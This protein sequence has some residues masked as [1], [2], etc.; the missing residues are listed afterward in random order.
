VSS[1]E[2]N[3]KKATE[4]YYPD[5]D[6]SVKWSDDLPEDGRKTLGDWL[7]K[8]TET[9]IQPV[10][11]A[12]SDATT[13]IDTTQHPYADPSS[14]KTIYSE[15]D[16]GIDI[17]TGVV[18]LGPDGNASKILHKVAPT[19]STEGTYLDPTTQGA[20]TTLGRTSE[21]LTKNRFSPG[22][23]FGTGTDK[24]AN[25]Q[26]TDGFAPAASL[27]RYNKDFEGLA[28]KELTMVAEQLLL[29]A[30]GDKT[31]GF[32]SAGKD[33][34][35]F[36]T[37]A[38]GI[39]GTQ[40]GGKRD[41]FDADTMFRPAYAVNAAKS[42]DRTKTV[43][44]NGQMQAVMGELNSDQNS[45]TS[46]GVLNNHLE[47]FAPALPT[48][49]ILLAAIG[50]IAS[51]IAAIVLALI[52]DVLGAIVSLIAGNG[53]GGGMNPTPIY[54]LDTEN[55]DPSKLP[56][57]AAFG[58]DDFGNTDFFSSLYKF[59]GLPPLE[60]KYEKSFH[61]TLATVTGA[62]EFFIGNSFSRVAIPQITT[63]AAG[64][65]VVIVRNAIRDM[66]QISKA[67]DE[68]SGGGT[69]GAIEGF[70]GLIDAF[71]SSATFK[72]MLTMVQI[73]DRIRTGPGL[74]GNQDNQ[75]DRWL[76]QRLLENSPG[77]TQTSDLG[78]L[79]RIKSDSPRLSYG[80]GVLPQIY[81]RP[82]EAFVRDD[83]PTTT[84]AIDTNTYSDL[85][86]MVAGGILSSDTI[87]GKSVVPLE[88]GLGGGQTFMNKLSYFENGR[89]STELREA[90][91]NE[92]NTYYMPFYFHDLRTNEIIP[93]PA[94]VSAISDAFS[95]KYSE[96]SSFGRM[97]PVM[98]Y[99]GTT[100]KIGFSFYMVATNEDDY[101]A[102]Y[103]GINK[104]VSLVY[105]QWGGATQISNA[106]GETFNRP[107]S[108]VQTA[109]PLIRLRLG[110]L[111]AS[112]RTPET[113]RRL[114]G[115]NLEE[116]RQADP[117][118]QDSSSPVQPTLGDATEQANIAA[119]DAVAK[120]ANELKDPTAHTLIKGT[121]ITNYGGEA[122]IA[123]YAGTNPMGSGG[124]MTLSGEPFLLPHGT[125]VRIKK[126]KYPAVEWNGLNDYNILGRSTNR[127]GSKLGGCPASGFD[128]TIMNYYIEGASKPA[129]EKNGGYLKNNIFYVV[130][131]YRD[132]AG[133]WIVPISNVTTVVSHTV[134]TFSPVPPAPPPPPL[135]DYAFFRDNI[136]VKS[137][138]ESGG[139]G[140]AGTIM[141]LDFDWNEAP[142][143]TS[144]ELGRAPKYVKVSLSFAPIHDEPL[145][146]NPDGSLRAAAYPVGDVITNIMGPRFE[147]PG[148]PPRWLQ[149]ENLIAAATAIT[150][151]NTIA[152]DA[153]SDDPSL[154]PELGQ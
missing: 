17:K 68:M 143:E 4:I 127:G 77:P 141:S 6:G 80:F 30:V 42:A 51:I 11:T 81:I 62:L 26:K 108:Y 49:M 8:I 100:R 27:G 32:G 113:V 86:S 74:L 149:H 91:E 97:D 61:F 24:W 28:M 129:I 69:V 136:L 142:W 13:D 125:R 116:F 148:Q 111:F 47:Q 9:N 123:N 121:Q 98:I 88:G 20:G 25:T 44:I 35:T 23:S 102:L 38:G 130:H 144:S 71:T 93:L 110:E 94:F 85:Q 14:I 45:R 107:Y 154:E 137:M 119:L 7:N 31:S 92:L 140:I 73:G 105:P 145:G 101:S 16:A 87:I 79:I 57:G 109:S 126:A 89:I 53:I 66:E 5:A 128:V 82:K 76:D 41:S 152:R 124:A 18:K 153:E 39:L 19:T 54:Q 22:Y 12:Q 10:P 122:T 37:G 106:A 118:G 75:G 58:N 120:N 59:F 55:P 139:A 132:D 72:F 3:N 70:F 64:Y 95:P 15:T 46:Y 83:I 36:D 29:N 1:D 60:A 135:T 138:R 96:V 78:Q 133:P 134:V 115:A 52:I 114:F 146:L 103:Y 147:L 117:H 104:L 84:N 90:M 67:A 151:M 63:N 99:G 150:N 43:N 131:D 56:F 40:L 2:I 65:Y 34:A 33:A 48:S 112:N 21:V 50:A